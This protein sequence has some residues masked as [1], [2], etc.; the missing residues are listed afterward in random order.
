VVAPFHG[1]SLSGFVVSAAAPSSSLPYSVKKVK[2]VVDTEPL[3]DA[4]YLELARWVGSM[5]FASLGETLAA[6]IPGA[7]REAE[8]PALAVD[9]EEIAEQPLNLSDEQNQAVENIL[10]QSGGLYYLFGITG[11]GKTEVFLRAAAGTLAEGRSV[12]Y[13]VPE[14][15]LTGQVSEAIRSR[16]GTGAAVLHSRLTPSQRLAEWRRILRGEVSLVVGARSAVFAPLKNLGLIILDEEHEGSYKSGASPRYHARQVAMRR[17][18]VSKARLVMGSATPSVEAYSLMRAGNLRELRLTRRLAGGNMPRVEVVNLAGEEG[19]FSRRLKEAVFATW[20]AGRQTILFLNRRGFSHFFHCNSCGYEMK[21][22][23]CSVGLTYHKKR[24]R[25]VC[26]YCGSTALPLEV[27]PECGSLDVGFFG[28][29]TEKIEEEAARIFPELKV[30]RIDTDSVKRKGQLEKIL[31]D[32]R[33]GRIDLLLGTQMVAKGLNFRGV[34]LVG[35][36]LADTGLHLPDFRAL[37]RTFAL[38]VQVSGRAGRFAAGGQVIVQTY[39][40]ENG[41]IRCAAAG[42][43]EDFYRN[44]LAVRKALGFPPFCRLF[45]LVF[46]GGREAD[47]ASASENYARV[48]GAKLAAFAEILGP[49]EC[50]LAVI[51]GKHRYQLLI[52]TASFSRV[53]AVLGGVLKTLKPAQDVYLEVDVDP[54]GLL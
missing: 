4:D 34:S 48:L 23:R 35:I 39:A 44:E 41:A 33:V 31:E 6:M 24:N 22:R 25:M 27:C 53:H 28:F 17:C 45:R 14:I 13:L 8:G 32:F 40:P 52:R 47:V 30:A 29:G 21:C 18:A 36:V 46:R 11:S 37:E 7:R 15:A 5:Y 16:F 19:A 54:Q 26:H 9:Q 43:I 20:K 42:G 3:F 12:I 1:R 49:S 10:K 51:A 2:R 50:P 38:I